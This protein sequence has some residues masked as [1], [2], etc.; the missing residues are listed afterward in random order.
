MR[1]AIVIP[2]KFLAQAN[3]RL[4]PVVRRGRA[5]LITAPDYRAAKEMAAWHIKK[6]WKGEPMTIP[7]EVVAHCYFPDA[8]K[9]DASN[10]AKMIG[11]AMTGIVLEDD[12]LIHRETYEFTAIDRVNPRVE[13]I[14]SA[15]DK[16][17]RPPKAPRRVKATPVAPVTLPVHGLGLD[18]KTPKHRSAYDRP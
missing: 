12:S 5:R 2:W 15:M 13:L 18:G 4:M 1:P 3:H 6:H 17:V 14:V 11:D 9:R 7:V 8:R 10:L 16:D